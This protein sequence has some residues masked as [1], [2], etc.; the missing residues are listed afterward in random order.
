M[1]QIEESFESLAGVLL[2]EY[3][4]FERDVLEDLLRVFDSEAMK[5]GSGDVFGRIYEYFLMKFLPDRS[6]CKPRA[7]RASPDYSSSHFDFLRNR[8]GLMGSISARTAP[9]QGIEVQRTG[10]E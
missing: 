2:R 10:F 3:G 6:L 8:F 7:R 4:I 1:D 9:T 5:S